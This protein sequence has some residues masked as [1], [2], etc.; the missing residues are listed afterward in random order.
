MGVVRDLNIMH[1]F[2]W[3]VEFLTFAVRG[4]KVDMNEASG[5]LKTRTWVESGRRK[6]KR[7][8]TVSL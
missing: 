2:S 8:P 6:R 5:K 1:D 4:W 3:R 7:I